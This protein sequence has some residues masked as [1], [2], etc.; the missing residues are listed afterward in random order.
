MSEQ[1]TQAVA[2][3]TASTA[4][5]SSTVYVSAGARQLMSGVIPPGPNPAVAL[6]AWNAAPTS[7]DFTPAVV[8]LPASGGLEVA[9]LATDTDPRGLVRL[10]ARTGTGDAV[11]VHPL[12]VY[13]LA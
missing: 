6:V 4:A 11:S 8:A 5:P 2:P 7:E 9:R 3:A 10:W 12:G 1:P 13:T